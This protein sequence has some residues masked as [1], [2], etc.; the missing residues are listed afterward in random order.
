MGFVSQQQEKGKRKL[1]IINSIFYK[2]DGKRKGYLVF[3][4][5]L[6][7]FASILT[8]FASCKNSKTETKFTI[9]D[10]VAATLTIAPKDQE[11][12]DTISFLKDT[13]FDF[14]TYTISVKE[15]D[16]VNIP[17][18]YSDAARRKE[19]YT[20]HG[21]FHDAAKELENYL[22]KSQSKYFSRTQEVLQLF[23]SNGQKVELRDVSK[24]SDEDIYYTYQNYFSAINTYLI[25]GQLYEGDCYLIVN[26]DNGEKKFIIGEIY[27]SPSGKLIIAINEDLEAGY[28]NNGMQLIE[29]QGGKYIKKFTIEGGGWA[30]VSLKWISDRSVIIRT[31]ERHTNGLYEYKTKFYELTFE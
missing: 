14:K 9:K 11:R 4:K 22:S 18:L 27:P 24:E 19:I 2:S 7:I 23:L 1:F 31:N 25:R 13:T 10:T 3:M 20:R 12:V 5:I 26:R 21:N 8:L 17:P 28:S 15:V 16:S 29:I 30:P 6:L